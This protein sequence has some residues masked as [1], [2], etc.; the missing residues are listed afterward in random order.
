MARSMLRDWVMELTLRE[1]G[2]LLVALRGCDSAPKFPL[3]SPERRMT[4]ALRYAIC[5]PFDER[6]VDASPGCFMLSQPPADVKLSHFE[7]YPQHWVGHVI[8]ACEVLGYRHPDPEY[9]A[10]WWRLYTGFCR[11]LH[12]NP[13]TEQQMTQ[14][15]NEDRIASNTVVSL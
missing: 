1:Q 13:E 9:S 4:A 6:E 8:H 3:D 2:T 14:R 5:V 12:V 15:L 10:A 7:H 11:S